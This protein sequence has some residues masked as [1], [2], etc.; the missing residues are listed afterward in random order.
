MQGAQHM[1]YAMKS[2]RAISRNHYGVKSDVS[3]T[4]C[5]RNQGLTIS[6]TFTPYMLIFWTLSI[7]LVFKT[8]RFG[9]RICLRP[10]VNKI[11]GL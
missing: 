6:E 7:V 5:L 10:H 1:L 4:V 9:D 11:R 3:E 2:P 8:R